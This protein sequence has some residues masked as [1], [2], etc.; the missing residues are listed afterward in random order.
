MPPMVPNSRKAIIAGR[1]EKLSVGF[2][3]YLREFDQNPAFIR[4]GQYESHALTMKLRRTLGSVSV[5]LRP[6]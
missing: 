4:P 1:V 2:E 5:A 6:D 3:R